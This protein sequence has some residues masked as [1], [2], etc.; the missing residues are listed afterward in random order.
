MMSSALLHGPCTPSGSCGLMGCR[1]LPCNKCSVVVSKLTYAAPAWRGFTTSTDSQRIDGISRRG[2]KSG[3]W[4]SDSPTFEGLCSSADDKLFIKTST[5]TNHIL[6]LFLPPLSTASQ[7]Y[8][9]RRRT[10]SYQFPGHSTYLS[11]CN[12]LTAC[13]TTTPIRH[14]LSFYCSVCACTC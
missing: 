2:N 3:L 13:C 8:S 9:R 7:S 5:Y 14:Y 1:S 11:D 12:F 4:T 6:N 10:H